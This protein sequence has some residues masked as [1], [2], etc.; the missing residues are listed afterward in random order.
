MGAQ[1]AVSNPYDVIGRM[2]AC[3]RTLATFTTTEDFRKV[4]GRSAVMREHGFD[5]DKIAFLDFGRYG[6]WPAV[7]TYFG[8]IYRAKWRCRTV[9]GTCGTVLP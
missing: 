9:L 8:V 6:V 2:E 7:V 1:F 4:G 5:P 3:A